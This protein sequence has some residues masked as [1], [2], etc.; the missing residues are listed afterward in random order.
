FSCETLRA[1][2]YSVSVQLEG[3]FRL[4]H[5]AVSLSENGGEATFVLN[6]L[7]EVFESVTVAAP[8]PVVDP[9]DPQSQQNVSGAELLAVPY[10]NTNNLKNA[11][12]IVPGVVRDSSGG[13]HLSGGAE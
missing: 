6:P 7:R 9:E 5:Q 13:I 4:D 10:P 2:K 8:S 3:F 12:R 11:L 1:G